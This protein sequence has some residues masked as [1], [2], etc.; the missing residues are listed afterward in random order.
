MGGSRL[1][2]EISE[3]SHS[4]LVESPKPATGVTPSWRTPGTSSARSQ[5]HFD[6]P[7]PSNF[8]PRASQEGGHNDSAIKPM[9]LP[10]RPKQHGP[11]STK[12]PRPVAGTAVK[13]DVRPKPYTLE[14][15]AAAPRY[16]PNGML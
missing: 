3:A 13:K 12:K 11:P 1:R 4:D 14:V 15:P 9:P 7:N 6:V 5:H 2:L 16:P 10:V 8:S